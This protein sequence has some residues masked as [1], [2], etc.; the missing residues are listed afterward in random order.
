[1]NGPRLYTVTAKRNYTIS[2]ILITIKDS[3]LIEIPES[4]L[5][6]YFV[7]VCGGGGVNMNACSA[8]FISC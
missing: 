7:C 3:Q 2:R 5:F 4:I 1:M 6:I 8:N